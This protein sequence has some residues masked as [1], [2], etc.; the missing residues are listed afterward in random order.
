MKT[1]K[2]NYLTV[3]L[4]ALLLIPGTMAFAQD[5]AVQEPATSVEYQTI[6]KQYFEATG[7]EMAH[8][9]IESMQSTGTISIP[10]AGIEG[11][12]TTTQTG[13][14]AI[15]KMEMAGIGSEMS[16]YDGETAW[17]ISEMTGPEIIDGDQKTQMVKQLDLNPFM[18]LEEKY[19]SVEVEGPEEFNGEECH[20]LVLKSEGFD[21]IYHYFSTNSHMHV[22]TRMTQVT[23]MGPMEMVSKL[24]DYREVAGVQMPHATTVELPNGMSLV[25]EVEKMEA[26]SVIEDSVFALPD[27]IKDL[28]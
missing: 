23:Q 22:G 15:M 24:S 18:D 2:L 17:R 14:K 21:P 7:G 1:K 25:T 19:D 28:Q 12:M 20:V 10:E 4:A 16:G 6:L 26:N 5:A 11:T 8:K 3:A 27:E 9:G 13:D